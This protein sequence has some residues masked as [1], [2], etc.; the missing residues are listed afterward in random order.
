MEEDQGLG[1]EGGEEGG[2]CEGEDD[3]RGIRRGEMR[4]IERV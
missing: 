1:E 3:V 2:V 4:G